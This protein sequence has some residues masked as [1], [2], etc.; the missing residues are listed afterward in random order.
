M[1]GRIARVQPFLHVFRTARAYD[2]EPA[3]GRR[4]QSCLLE[5]ADHMAEPIFPGCYHPP[6]MPRRRTKTRIRRRALEL[7]QFD[8]ERYVNEM[9]LALLEGRLSE[10]R[11]E[12][13]EPLDR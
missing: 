5:K 12:F 9:E 6:R 4:S 10:A 7:S 2:R 8:Y 11:I 1:S 3:N 13:W